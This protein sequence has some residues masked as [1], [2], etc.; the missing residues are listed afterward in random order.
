M[1]WCPERGPRINRRCRRSLD[2]WPVRSPA[3]GGA[4]AVTYATNDLDFPALVADTS[5]YYPRFVMLDVAAG[6]ARP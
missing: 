4:V 5:L 2:P 3:L 1:R 6:A